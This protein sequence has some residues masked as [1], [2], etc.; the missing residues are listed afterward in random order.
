MESELYGV[1]STGIRPSVSLSSSRL[2]VL[3]GKS[4]GSSGPTSELLE[5]LVPIWATLRSR[6]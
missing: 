2:S 4:A 6:R 1:L 3:L 5:L